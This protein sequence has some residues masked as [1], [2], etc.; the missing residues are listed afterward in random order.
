[1]TS[2]TSSACRRKGFAQA[3]RIGV[4]NGLQRR[5]TQLP[6]DAT[7]RLA[8]RSSAAAGCFAHKKRD[9]RRVVRVLAAPL[10]PLGDNSGKS[11]S[12]ALPR[13]AAAGNTTKSVPLEK[14]RASIRRPCEH[15]Q[16]ASVNATASF[17]YPDT[18][19]A[20]LVEAQGE[21]VGLLSFF[22]YRLSL[23]FPLAIRGMQTRQK[24]VN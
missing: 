13:A 21:A 2:F 19:G 3:R 6:A 22:P 15:V 8:L 17:E 4:R 24:A 16:T 12:R 9:C 23:L 18:R 1:M 10:R 5:S 20:I 11:S 14:V 7:N